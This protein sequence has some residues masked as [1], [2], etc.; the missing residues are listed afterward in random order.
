MSNFAEVEAQVRQLPPEQRARLA[1]LLLESLV[2]VSSPSALAAWDTEIRARV[3]AYERGE[4]ELVPAE[5][6]F[7]RARKLAE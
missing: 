1:A 4:V 2:E 7:A 6:V 5:D 3:A